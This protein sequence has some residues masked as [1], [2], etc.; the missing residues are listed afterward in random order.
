MTNLLHRL[1][2]TLLSAGLA[3]LLGLSVTAHAGTASGGAATVTGTGE[4]PDGDDGPETGPAVSFSS[5]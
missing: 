3:A 5:D 1:L 2:T 4:D